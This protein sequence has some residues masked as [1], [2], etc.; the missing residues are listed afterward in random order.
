[1][2]IY[3][4]VESCDDLGYLQDSIVGYRSYEVFPIKVIILRC[5]SDDNKKVH[6][7]IKPFRVGKKTWALLGTV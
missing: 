4:G 2:P 7:T 1:M 3:Y 6:S 5:L